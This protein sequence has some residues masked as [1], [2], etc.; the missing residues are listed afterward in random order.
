MPYKDSLE[1]QFANGII[2]DI[3]MGPDFRYI[4]VLEETELSFDLT[5]FI[6]RFGFDLDRFDQNF[7][8]IIR[9]YTNDSKELWGL[10]Y[11]QNKAAL[12]YNKD[13]FDLFGVPYPTDDMTYEEVIDLA[14]QVTGERGG[15]EFTGLVM[16]SADRYIF[17]P[18]G[19]TLLDPE[20][21]QPKYLEE[22]AF[23]D[24]FATYQHVDE[25]QGGESSV[26]GDS[27]TSLFISEQRLA[28]LP[29]YFLGLDWTGLLEAQEQG[30][31]WDIVTFPK[32]EG[33]EDVSAF[34]DGYWLGISHIVSIKSRPLK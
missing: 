15:T 32:W 24:V 6:E 23:Q 2:P 10:P 14:S 25:F 16:P 20:T 4:P 21:D 26:H 5:R 30:M 22:P 7:L 31:N 19:L 18:L 29:M 12:H 1:E 9:S 11:M 33:Q 8:N 13:I 27:A 28:M 17:P 3:I 34:A